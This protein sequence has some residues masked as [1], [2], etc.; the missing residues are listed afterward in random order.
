MKQIKRIIKYIKEEFSI[1][2]H[3]AGQESLSNEK[4]IKRSPNYPSLLLREHFQSTEK[5]KRNLPEFGSLSEL[6]EDSWEA[7]IDRVQKTEYQT[8]ESCPER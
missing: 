3:E 6:R 7:K 1:I 2:G 5:R 8:Q 4:K